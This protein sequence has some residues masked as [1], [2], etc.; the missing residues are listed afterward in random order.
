MSKV[1][2]YFERSKYSAPK[3]EIKGVEVVKETDKQ[4]KVLVDYGGCRTINKSE[5]SVWDYAFYETKEEAV[6]GLNDYCIS[7]IAKKND[8]IERAQ[9][10]IAKYKEVIKELSK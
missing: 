4:Y 8:E 9:K 2:Y 7:M 10:I 1:L 6:K 3:S 5:M